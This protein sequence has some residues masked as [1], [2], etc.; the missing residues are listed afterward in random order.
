MAIAH[1][2]VQDI[3]NTSYAGIIRIRLRVRA[4]RRISAD[5]PSDHPGVSTPDFSC[6]T[7]SLRDHPC[8]TCIIYHFAGFVK[9]FF[10]K[11]VAIV[12]KKAKLNGIKFGKNKNIGLTKTENMV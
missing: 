3:Q 4:K 12:Y 1:S 6:R 5:R 8:R 9:G 11:T 7:A 10:K 2:P